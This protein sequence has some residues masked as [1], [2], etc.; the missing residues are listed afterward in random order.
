MKSTATMITSSLVLLVCII[1]TSIAIAQTNDGPN[2]GKKMSVQEELTA[3]GPTGPLAGTLTLPA[4][5]VPLPMDLPVFLIVPGS[6]PTDR[7]GNSPLGVSAAPY[8]L[9]AEELAAR[10]YASA[11]IDKR[12]MFGS[13]AAA[14]DPNDVT[15]AA[16]GDD[17]QA[18]IEAIQERLPANSGARCVIP[19]GHSEGGL[20][21]L[22][23]MTRLTDACGLILIA[24]IGRPLDVVLREQLHANAANAP[25]LTEAELALEALKRGDR[26]D[27]SAL[28]PELQPLFGPE[29]QGFLIDAMSYDPLN[30]AAQVQ[31]PLLVL[32]G[33]RDLQVS[34][35]DARMLAHAAT[36]AK[37]SL[38]PDVNHVL[39]IVAS[40]DVAA[41][42]ATYANPDLPIAPD[43]V[44][45]VAQFAAK[46][47]GE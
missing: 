39:K 31:V 19:I 1:A 34:L 7:D 2:L 33:T 12:G 32:Q 44:D 20:V 16:Y 46:I 25:V 47:A 26:V 17:L 37:L 27:P 10:G 15:I 28:S 30:L 42:V 43:V 8:R 23:A 35:Q 29:V 14:E 11:R 4:G 21:A 22:A 6:G 13:T 45:A 24:S 3:A 9:L 36:D 40:E 38:V 18:W 5:D 41:N